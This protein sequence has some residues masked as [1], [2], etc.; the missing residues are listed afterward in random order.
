MWR[1]RRAASVTRPN[2]ESTR[3]R[4]SSIGGFIIVSCERSM[5]VCQGSLSGNADAS[6][7]PCG[8]PGLVDD[9]QQL[10]DRVVEVV[11]D[12][13]V[14]GQLRARSAPRSRPCAAARAPCPRGRRARAG[15][16]PARSR[17]G[18][19]TKIR[20][21]SSCSCLHLLGAVDLDLEHDVAAGGRLRQR[22]AVE[23]AEELGP[24]EEATVGDA[25]LELLPRDEHVRA[26]GLAR[27]AAPASSTTATATAGVT[28]RRAGPRWCSCRR[29]P[30]RR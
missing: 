9:A 16:V 19:S 23:V 27:P 24:L 12:D 20:I 21:A 8:R 4:S 22:R 2:F 6:S 14:V 25:L 18:G 29:R 5:C 7:L 1:A 11:V 15:D 3:P 10:V 17:V 26:F 13:D 30:A 28:R